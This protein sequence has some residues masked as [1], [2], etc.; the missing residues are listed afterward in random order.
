MVQ[1]DVNSGWLVVLMILALNVRNALV[2]WN[3]GDSS[4][5][6]DVINNSS[7]VVILAV[8][9]GMGMLVVVVC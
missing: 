9:V 3:R 8:F 7:E 2:H 4:N 1:V 5:K 6:S